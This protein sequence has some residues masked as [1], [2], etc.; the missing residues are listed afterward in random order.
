VILAAFTRPFWPLFLHVLGAMTLYGVVLTA[1]ITSLVA[2]RRP[3]VPVLRRA[4]FWALV[5]GV[6]AYLLLRVFAQVIYSDEKVAFGGTDPTWVGIGFMTSDLGLLI[7]I[8]SIACAWWWQRSG[9][10]RAGR[11]VAVLSAV[12]LVL[13]SVAL[14]AMSGKWG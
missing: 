12:Y 4:T 2:W 11:I 6:P 14:L 13:L 5:S 1:L 10:P 7:L 9:K 8:A 3:D